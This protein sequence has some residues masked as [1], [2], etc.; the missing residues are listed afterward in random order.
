M[1]I[2]LKLFGIFTITMLKGHIP[3]V[4]TQRRNNGLGTCPRYEHKSGA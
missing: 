4:F 1:L 2:V 3:P